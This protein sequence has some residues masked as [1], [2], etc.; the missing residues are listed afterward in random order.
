[1]LG[2]NEV[3]TLRCRLRLSFAGMAQFVSHFAG[4]EDSEYALPVE[5][6]ETPVGFPLKCYNLD[7]CDFCLSPSCS[8]S[9]LEFLVLS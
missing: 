8:S 6:G 9:T 4:P 5:K 7:T 3:D 2:A 1:M